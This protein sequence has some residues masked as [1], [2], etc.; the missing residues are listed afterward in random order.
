MVSS[1]LKEWKGTL[2]VLDKTT[3]ISWRKISEML[4]KTGLPSSI[5][6]RSRNNSKE[7]LSL[8][9]NC[10]IDSDFHPIF[11]FKN[12][13]DVVRLI[14]EQLRCTNVR[15]KWWEFWY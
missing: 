9:L 6:T 14:S 11:R 7:S 1:T 2:I 8:S 3:P 13:E 5:S 12:G 10:T 15:K 4:F